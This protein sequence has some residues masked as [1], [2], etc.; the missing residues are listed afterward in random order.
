MPGVPSSDA[1]LTGHELSHTEDE[2]F[3]LPNNEDNPYPGGIGDILQ[4]PSDVNSKEAG[5]FVGDLLKPNSQNSK[6]VCSFNAGDP[7]DS[8]RRQNAMP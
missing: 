8:R 2:L 5:K 6:P 7:Q 4:Q 3:R 1:V